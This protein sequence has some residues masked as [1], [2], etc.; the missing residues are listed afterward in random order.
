VEVRQLRHVLALVE[1]ENFRKAA[2]VLHLSQPSLTK[3]IQQL[4]RTCGVR[5]FERRGKSVVPTVFGQLVAETARQVLDALDALTRKINETTNLEAGELAVGAGPYA[6]E[7][8]TCSLRTSMR[9]RASRS[10]GS[11]RCRP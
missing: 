2:E 4:E 8:S 7:I 1:H 6:A 3:S 9:F 10:S 5:L 11:S